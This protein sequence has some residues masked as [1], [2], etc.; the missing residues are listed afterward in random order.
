VVVRLAALEKTYTAVSNI[1]QSKAVLAGLTALG[2]SQDLAGSRYQNFSS[3]PVV[4][5]TVGNLEEG[6]HGKFRAVSW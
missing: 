3:Q 6:Y 1:I 2:L 5:N 4:R